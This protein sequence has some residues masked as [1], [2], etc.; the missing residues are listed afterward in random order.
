MSTSSVAETQ[1]LTGV[2]VVA[3]VAY[4]PVIRPGARP[5]AAQAEPVEIDEAARPGEVTRMKEAAAAVADR[6]RER[7]G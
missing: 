7:A 5:P 3:G 4:A 2:P 6:L 1:V